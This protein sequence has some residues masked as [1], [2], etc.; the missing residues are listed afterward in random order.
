MNYLEFKRQLMVDPYSTDQT[1]LAAK[2]QDEQ[3]VQAADEADEFER[4]LQ[5][6]VNVEVPPGLAEQIMLRTS[7]EEGLRTDVRSEPAVTSR[8]VWPQ[9]LAAGLFAAAITAGVMNWNQPIGSAGE[10]E[11]METYVVEHWQQH[12]A[13]AIQASN[14]EF[15]TPEELKQ[16]L[17]AVGVEANQDFLE[18]VR[19]GKNCPT[20]KGDGVHLVIGTEHGPITLFYAPK[21]NSETRRMSIDDVV[22]ILVQMQSGSAA[23]VGEHETEESMREIGDMINSSL[24]PMSTNT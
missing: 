5:Q 17:A 15:S 18:R 3:F 8:P 10:P 20:P 12:G 14:A 11:S 13:S 21:V 2:E 19:Y 24:R 4:L 1:F 22:A 16:V 23:L 7:I 6:A 9:A